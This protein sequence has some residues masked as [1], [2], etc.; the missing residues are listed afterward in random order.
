M[1]RLLASIV[2]IAILIVSLSA[3]DFG[4]PSHTDKK[5]PTQQNN[6]D[7]I[8]TPNSNPSKRNTKIKLGL[9]CELSETGDK[10]G[11]VVKNAVELAV[12]EI[13][14]LGG[15]D[16]LKFEAVILDSN[17]YISE[18]ELYEE[19]FGE[20][21][22]IFLGSADG[23][24]KAA[25]VYSELAEEDGIFLLNS[26]ALNDE[27]GG[28]ETTYSMSCAA[29]EQG[30]AAA[31]FFNENYKGKSIGVLYQSDIDYSSKMYESF[32]SSLDPYFSVACAD[33]SEDDYLFESQ[34][35]LLKNCEVLFLPIEYDSAWLFM[36]QMRTVYNEV[37]TYVG[38]DRLERMNGI[39]GFDPSTIEQEIIFFSYFDSY[40]T[41]GPVVDFMVNYS[42][43]YG[44][45]DD[46]SATAA[47]AY[48]SVYAIYEALRTAKA[49]GKEIL[50]N[51]APE[52]FCFVLE[53]VFDSEDFVFRGITG[54]CENGERSFISWH[55]RQAQMRPIKVT[56]K[57]RTN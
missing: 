15:I 7:K 11:E 55:E 53:E 35:Q 25:A 36:S 20:G 4:L 43:E 27:N 6:K 2:L 9:A 39:E 31:E 3:C 50:A 24:S 30:K 48:D 13:N 38:C 8:N 1:K 52:E 22:Q 23:E 5:N 34:I 16:G 54:E 56:L 19:L 14:E 18:K 10:T 12:K 17:N 41:D 45:V 32:E 51:T 33:F 49:N 26:A 40:A 44:G 46:L 47:A 21:M 57:N 29:G 37:T 42:T 28:F